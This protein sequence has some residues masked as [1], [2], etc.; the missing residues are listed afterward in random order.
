M[1]ES[2][3]MVFRH[4]EIIGSNIKMKN[5]LNLLKEGLFYFLFIGFLFFIW[6][7]FFTK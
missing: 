7:L 1:V 3:L 5:S 2:L 4:G 6:I